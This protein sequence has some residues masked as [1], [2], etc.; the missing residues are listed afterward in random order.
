MKGEAMRGDKLIGLCTLV[1][2]GGNNSTLTN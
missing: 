2:N 1:R